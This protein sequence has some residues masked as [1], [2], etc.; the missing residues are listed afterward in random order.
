MSLPK[1]TVVALG[2]CL[3][4]IHRRMAVYRPSF[5]NSL[6]RIVSG[7]TQPNGCVSAFF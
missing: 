7:N 6:K 5:N 2:E 4:A 1:Q 3:E